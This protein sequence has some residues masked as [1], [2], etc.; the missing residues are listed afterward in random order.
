MLTKM[1]FDTANEDC[2]KNGA[3][4]ASITDVWEQEFL[5]GM[6]NKK[7][8]WLGGT[9]RNGQQDF[10]WINGDD[11][12]TGFYDNFRSPTT[13]THLEKQDCIQM[14]E[15]GTWNDVVCTKKL[16]FF[17]QKKA[18]PGANSEHLSF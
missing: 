18:S 15:D 1:D 11:G 14:A 3:I 13:P 16:P 2:I 8:T 9:D 12:P 10:R 7:K 5:A 17:C 6:A 4:L